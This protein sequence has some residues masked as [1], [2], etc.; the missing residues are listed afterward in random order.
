RNLESFKKIARQTDSI[1][2][3]IAPDRTDAF[4]AQI[5]YPVQ[6]AALMTE[7][8]IEAQRAR[9]LATGQSG[10]SMWNRSDALMSACARSTNAYRKIRQLTRHYNDTLAGG[11]WRHLM[12]MAPRDLYVFNPPILPIGL[13][14]AEC[15]EYGSTPA[16]PDTTRLPDDFIAMNSMDFNQSSCTVQPVSM[17]GHSMNAVPLPKGEK[18]PYSF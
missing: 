16:V 18:L 7:K 17:L 11:K 9:S 5:L 1:K 3:K 12:N 4:F 14:D 2:L 13:S 6:S 15:C 10:E 8:A